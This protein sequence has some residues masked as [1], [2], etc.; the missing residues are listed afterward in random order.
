MRWRCVLALAAAAALCLPCASGADRAPR[1]LPLPVGAVRPKGWIREQLR[2]DATEGLA[3]HF[4]QLR[5]TYGVRTYRRKDGN[6]G[7]GEMT[8]N[9]ADGFIRMAYLCGD[10]GAKKKA[11]EFVRAVLQTRGPDGYLG[12]LKPERRY[13]NAV[14]GELWTQSRLY[15]A[16]LAYYELTG[17]RRVLDAVVT[18]TKLTLSKYG[19]GNRPFE[20]TPAERAAAR[21][22]PVQSHGLMFV[23]VLEWLYRLTGDREYVC[24]AQFLYDDFSRAANI[25]DPDVQ[26][27]ILLNEKYPFFW[28]GVHTVE[29]LRVPLFLAYAGAGDRYAEAAEAGFRKLW[30]HIVPS[31]SCASDER[32]DNL[33]PTARQYYEY[34]T[35]TELCSTLESALAKTGRAE[36]GDRIELAVFNAAQAARTPDG[37]LISYLTADTRISA[38]EAHDFPYTG[39]RRCKLSPA[40]DVGGSCCSANSVKVMPY[41]VCSMWMRPREGGLAALLFGPC[42]VRAKVNGVEVAIEEKTAYPFSDEVAFVFAPARPAAFPLVVRLPRWAGE[43]NIAAP[44]AE[45]KRRG[46]LCVIEKTWRRGDSVKV[47]FENP[48]RI[49]RLPDGEASIYRGPL[50]FV[51][52]WPSR[53]VRLTRRKFRAPGFYEYDVLPKWPRY[54]WSPAYLDVRAKDFGFQP[55]RPANGDWLHPYARPPLVLK[56]VFRSASRKKGYRSPGRLVPIGSALLR[57]ASFRVWPFDGAYFSPRGQ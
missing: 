41:Y 56:G 46:A 57:F 8:G 43:I 28:H 38:T 3:A 50:L 29:Q 11:D 39:K 14:T 16:L 36:F 7:C 20:R 4:L 6:L 13:R 33:R 49:Q 5:P 35:T 22:R 24:F 2:R 53:M 40:H 26:L 48:I 55:E 32:I 15:V 31:G 17:D 27:R 10:A 44:G 1:F 19:P 9:W 42:Q 30:R 12:N 45:M 51:Q 34:C 54:D 18:A 37:K 25:D 23:D 52:P 21:G 47:T